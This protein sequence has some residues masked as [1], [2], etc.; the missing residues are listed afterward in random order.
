MFKEILRKSNPKV[1]KNSL[2]YIHKDILIKMFSDI[3]QG[4]ATKL[5]TAEVGCSDVAEKWN[6]MISTLCESRRTSVLDVNNVLQMV[7][8]MDSIRDMIKSVNTQTEA[9]HS[10]SASSEEL[11]VSIEDVSESV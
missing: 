7:T 5:T 3:I 4:K 10:M 6:E 9:L 2:G 1:T 8:T 11:S